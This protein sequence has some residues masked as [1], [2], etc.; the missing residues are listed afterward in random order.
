MTAEELFWDLVEPMCGDPAVRRSTMMG[1]PCVRLDGRFFAGLDRRNE[2]LLVRLPSARVREVIG[3]GHG[4]AFA[5]A[6]RIFREW[7]AVPAPDRR[8]WQALLAEARDHAARLPA[9][10][11]G[12]R[13]HRG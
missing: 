7:V 10:S 8:R 5:P 2:A 6:G 4:E 13:D 11:K 12:R 3:A 1:L 9:R